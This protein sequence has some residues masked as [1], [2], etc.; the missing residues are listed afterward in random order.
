M[1]EQQEMV[2]HLQP[3]AL[4]KI[5]CEYD[6]NGDFGGNNDEALA[7]ITFPADMPSDEYIGYIFEVVEKYVSEQTGLDADDLDGLVG[8]SYVSPVRL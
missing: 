6:I 5:W 3:S 8:W 2:L 4:V 1:T 7:R